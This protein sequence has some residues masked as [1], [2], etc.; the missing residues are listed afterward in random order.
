MNELK[1]LMY[2]DNVSKRLSE[3][4][5]RVLQGRNCTLEQLAKYKKVILSKLNSK[6][7]RNELEEI[8]SLIYE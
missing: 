5:K 3:A 8:I 4:I 2:Q 6:R 7:L 1:Y